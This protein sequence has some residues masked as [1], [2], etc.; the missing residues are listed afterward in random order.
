M[1]FGLFGAWIRYP[2]VLSST[3]DPACNRRPTLVQGKTSS[4]SSSTTYPIFR[5][6]RVQ[7]I[8]QQVGEFYAVPKNDVFRTVQMYTGLLNELLNEFSPPEGEIPTS[9]EY[10]Q[11]VDCSVALYGALQSNLGCATGLEP[12]CA[13]Y[14]MISSSS[15]GEAQANVPS[16]YYFLPN[17]MQEFPYAWWHKCVLLRGSTISDEQESIECAEWRQSTISASDMQNLHGL[18]DGED[19]RSILR[20]AEGGVTSASVR[21]ASRNL[22]NRIMTAFASFSASGAGAR[23]S[24][25]DARSKVEQ[26]GAPGTRIVYGPTGGMERLGAASDFNMKCYSK[27]FLPSEA[28]DF[29]KMGKADTIN[30]ALN[31]IMWVKNENANFTR[32]DPR[33]S[34]PGYGKPGIQPECFILREQDLASLSG[35][36]ELKP[37][38]EYIKERLE[39]EGAVL[40]PVPGGGGGGF[41]LLVS[42]GRGSL[43]LEGIEA[44]DFFDSRFNS[45][46]QG[47]LGLEFV[48]PELEG[49]PSVDKDFSRVTGSMTTDMRGF[50]AD[51][52][53]MP[54]VTLADMQP[55]LP[56]CLP[57]TDDPVDLEESH[58]QAAYD[59]AKQDI[60]EYA[61]RID[62]EPTQVKEYRY[63]PPPD[64]CVWDCGGL[65]DGYD[66]PAH[67]GLDDGTRDAFLDNLKKQLDDC[68]RVAAT[69]THCLRK[70]A[71]GSMQDAVTET[72]S[73][74][75][76]Q[77]V[78]SW[79]SHDPWTDFGAWLTVKYVPS[80]YINEYRKSIFADRTFKE[81]TGTWYQC[82]A[83]KVRTSGSSVV[84]RVRSSLS[85]NDIVVSQN[86]NLLQGQDQ[87][88]IDEFNR[89]IYDIITSEVFN[90]SQAGCSTSGNRCI[91]AVR[92]PGQPDR[93]RRIDDTFYYQQRGGQKC[94][95]LGVVTGNIDCKFWM[96]RDGLDADIAVVS[97][98]NNAPLTSAVRGKAA[99]WSVYTNDLPNP[100]EEYTLSYAKVARTLW[101]RFMDVMASNAT[102]SAQWIRPVPLPFFEHDATY[103]ASFVGFNLARKLDTERNIK[104]RGNDC[105]TGSPVI[106]YDKC[107][108]NFNALWKHAGESVE[109]HVR[110]RGPVVVPAKSTLVW[111]GLSYAHHMADAVPAWSLRGRNATQVFARW[112]FDQ[113]VQC[114]SG[115][116]TTVCADVSTSQVETDIRAV[117]PW[118]GGDYNPW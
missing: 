15:S 53:Q 3:L 83:I 102:L 77:E 60:L 2:E 107:S 115:I 47:L 1:F 37:V 68:K 22:K 69:R 65:W 29:M 12:M 55:E 19:V 58:C 41:S 61:A 49:L 106:Q 31:M 79:R 43:L 88:R 67:A 11:I 118:L 48:P 81:K 109:S 28:K 21:E 4:A 89:R 24:A 84:D 50:E 76:I 112:I 34:E 85:Y 75:Y 57:N 6:A 30:C 66:R 64:T 97:R 86:P 98:H 108:E 95:I 51:L 117:I 116:D 99:S 56:E 104:E 72:R 36:S 27:T 54:C 110:Q 70:S 44:A 92:R 32:Y 101:T 9:H 39:G 16:L 5:F 33:V 80:D 26:L 18:Y 71:A 25:Q 94:L 8:V 96:R 59:K 35:S 14:H 62:A 52:P 91:P 10:V 40:Q 17:T 63:P 87:S 105:G 111:P 82:D 20:R 38:M 113:N 103:R 90:I 78:C 73:R 100:A 23:S 13:D 74:N 7:S 45:N 46:T 114:T 42:E 93:S